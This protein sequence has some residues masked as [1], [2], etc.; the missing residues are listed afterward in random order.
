MRKD[1]NASVSL[2]KIVAI[3]LIFIILLGVAV[4]AGNAK[5]NSI[6]IEFSNNHEITIL[7]SK[8]KVSEILED[9]HII[10]ASNEVVIPGLDEEITSGKSIKISLEGT[11]E[12]KIVEIAE[13][14][15]EN[16]IE[17]IKQKYENIKEKIIVVKKEIPFE[18]ITKDVANRR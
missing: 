1:E 15:D 3:T 16:N 13:K 7:T 12:A 5:L 4:L 2:R 18:R 10:L 8:T 6:K 11:E 17:D 9:N 14:S